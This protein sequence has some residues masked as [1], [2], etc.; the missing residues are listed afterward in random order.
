MNKGSGRDLNWFWKK[1]FYEV[2]I[3]D[4]AISKVVQT[5]NQKQI[6]V[7][8]VGTKPVP[9]DLAIT[10]SDGSIRRIHQSIAAWEKGS[11]SATVKFSDARKIASIKLGSIHTPDSNKKNNIWPAKP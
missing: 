8:S 10:F 7:E 3:P 11:K 6:V 4:L 2:G 1:W 9:I 5:G